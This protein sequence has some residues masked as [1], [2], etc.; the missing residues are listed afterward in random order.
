M[1]V[2]AVFKPVLE[3]VFLIL[4]NLSA[5]KKESVWR[6]SCGLFS[7]FCGAGGQSGGLMTAARAYNAENP[8][9]QMLYLD[10]EKIRMAIC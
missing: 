5:L 10:K 7:R 9:L 6:G 2:F 4:D 8:N 1:A 3:E